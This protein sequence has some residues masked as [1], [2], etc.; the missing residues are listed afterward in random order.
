MDRAL[1]RTKIISNHLLQSNSSQIIS[2]NACL[3]YS[4]PEPNEVFQFDIKEM[5]KLLDGHNLKDRDW[6]YN[7][8]IQSKLFNPRQ[9]GE[10][11]FVSPDYNQ[12]MEQQREI[13]MRRISYLLERGVFRGWLTGQGVEP[14]LRRIAQS[15]V[16]EMF[17][18]SISIKLG[19]HFSLW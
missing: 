18:H 14:T 3:S 17:D 1:Q 2:A 4:P 6:L 9:V 19:V 15:E 7:L 12:P 5:R 8:V 11:V 10:K 13:T 16:L